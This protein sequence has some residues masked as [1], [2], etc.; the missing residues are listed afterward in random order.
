MLSIDGHL[1]DFYFLAIMNSTSLNIHLQ[2]LCGYIF[3]FLLGTY[4]GA[5]LLGPMVTLCLVF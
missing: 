3:L 4:P 5:E 2:V 1:V